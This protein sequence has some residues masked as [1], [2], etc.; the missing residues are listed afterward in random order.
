M[1]RSV[2]CGEAC[3]SSFWS[4]AIGTPACAQWTPEGVAEVVH[5]HIRPGHAGRVATAVMELSRERRSLEEPPAAPVV[6][7]RGGEDRI[8]RAAGVARPVSG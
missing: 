3:P 4:R 5:R 2:M 1:Y 8:S 7:E 6:T